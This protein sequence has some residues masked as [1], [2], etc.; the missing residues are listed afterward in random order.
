MSFQLTKD[1]N[2]IRR[3]FRQADIQNSGY[4]SIADFRHV[5]H[6]C[7]IDVNDDDLYHILSEF[8]TRLDGNIAYE[9]F[10]NKMIDNH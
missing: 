2:G 10:L 5:L 8:D 9:H 1:H 4:L 3:A 7:Q 6:S